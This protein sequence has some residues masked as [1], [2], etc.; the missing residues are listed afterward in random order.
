MKWDDLKI[1]LALARR[2]KL[3]IAAHELKMDIT[4]ISRR[5][6]RLEDD[7]GQ[8]LFERLR[9]G[10]K[11]TAQGEN[12]LNEAEKIE[13]SFYKINHPK[14]SISNTPSGT[15]RMS[16]AEGFGTAIFAP[17]LGEFNKLYPHIEIDLVAG[18]GFLSLSKR[19]ADVAI[20]LSRTKSKHIISEFLRPYY[21]H[22][23]AH[24]DNTPHLDKISNIRDL[25]DFTLIDYVDDLIYSDQLRY[26]ESM[27]PNCRPNIRSTSIIAQKS[28]VETGAGIAILP[29][30]LVG[31]DFIKILPN[32]ISLKRQFWFSYHQSVASLAKIKALRNFTFNHLGQY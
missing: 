21:L 15:I 22:L 12:L 19:E 9:S 23:Y 17:L 11:L 27:L 20:G 7:I 3:A 29:D 2:K 18:S 8:T 10:H 30:F 25:K 16:V 13:A 5:I 6:K 31:P 32:K 1:F 14:D 24:K 26:F 28:L 4:T